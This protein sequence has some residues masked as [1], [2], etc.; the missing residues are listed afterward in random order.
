MAYSRIWDL[1]RDPGSRC[2]APALLAAV[3][4]AGCGHTAGPEFARDAGERGP[5]EV[6]E[7]VVV[8]DCNETPI[9]NHSNCMELAEAILQLGESVY[10]ELKPDDDGPDARELSSDLDTFMEQRHASG[11]QRADELGH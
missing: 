3:V 10:D 8:K 4:L 11:L 1:N 7:M 2:P 6:K 5:V 9:N